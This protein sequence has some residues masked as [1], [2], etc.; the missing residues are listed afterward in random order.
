VTG[1]P[2]LIE[3]G[4]TGLLVPQR[5]PGSLAASLAALLD[6]EALRVDLALAARQRIEQLFDIARNSEALRMLFAEASEYAPLRMK[7]VARC[8]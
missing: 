8:V 4:V 2:E 1:I 6:D 7:E 5:D 3:H